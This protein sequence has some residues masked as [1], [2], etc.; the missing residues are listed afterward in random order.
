[1]GQRA[2]LWLLCAL[3]LM[4]PAGAAHGEPALPPPSA[5]DTI[6]LPAAALDLVPGV[7]VRRK[8]EKPGKLSTSLAELA[9]AA[10]SDLSGQETARIR[11]LRLEAGR[12]QVQIV[13]ETPDRTAVL[14]AVGAAGGE[15]TGSGQEGTILQAWVPP[16]GLEALARHPDILAIRQPA[17]LVLL[18]ESRGN[19][20]SEALDDFNVQ[21]WHQVGVTGQ[22]VRIGIVD[23]G[24]QGYTALLG[25]EL[26]ARVTVRN[27]VDGEGS[28]Q[29]D[30]T[31]GHGTAVAEI[32]HDIAPDARLFLAK[33]STNVDV[34]EAVAWLQDEQ[35]VDIIST[36]IG[37][38]NLA[39]GDGSG[40][41]AA[42]VA[43]ARAAGILWITAA[44]NERD[45]HWGGP[46]QDADNDGYVDYA[47]GQDINFF[48]PGNGSA[49]IIPAGYPIT[50]YAR[51]SDWTNVEQD[52]DVFLL[53]WDEQNQNYETIAK[54]EDLQDGRPGQT[55]TEIVRGMTS[56][57]PAAYAFAIYRYR[58]NRP[59]HFEVFLPKMLRP[60]KN[61]TARSLA[62]LADAPAAITV[63]AVDAASPYPQEPY[64]AEGPT[65]GPGGSAA[66]GLLKP[67]LAAYANISTA[68]YGSG[69]R[70]N[71][72]SAA[73]PHVA[74]AAALLHQ[75]HPAATPDQLQALL[76]AQA[77]D[78]GAP[79]RDTL[80]GH[81]RLN[82]PL[83]L[84][85]LTPSRLEVTPAEAAVGDVVTY[86][87]RLANHGWLTATASLENPRPA[88]LWLQGDPRISGGAP[89]LTGSQTLTWT[90]PITPGAAV[91][92]WYTAT[93][94]GSVTAEP[95]RIVNRVQVEDGSGQTTQL[96]AILNPLRVFLAA[97]LRQ[98]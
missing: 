84:P 58:G 31:T 94:T 75:I 95:L 89:P 22:G 6:R 7:E 81:G 60:D 20:T 48:G 66:G 10:G 37:F 54:G 56:G 69:D 63:A 42:M 45:K 14:Q 47:P 46:S 88:G 64:S 67:D 16:A 72:T 79:G 2:F 34:E 65:N 43:Q 11:G 87:I 38:Y 23:G 62:N 71:G 68:S 50:L 73:T 90:G 1:M 44:G 33:A 76:E 30:G 25:Q 85:D 61:V 35:R 97:I 5:L 36:S 52:Y 18:E 77:V 59:V 12:V 86:T 82:L 28:A 27:F 32:I 13:V 4:A 92:L 93:L 15:V 57:V 74:G 96:T 51:W 53:R 39:P 40:S 41:L 19:Y 9:A 80:F 8:Q 98:E 91:S 78:L 24:F 17:R 26:P 3:L 83:P 70:F 21:A 55:P 49:Y 29:V